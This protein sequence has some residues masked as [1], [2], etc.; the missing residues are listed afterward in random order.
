VVSSDLTVGDL[1]SS[2]TALHVLAMVMTDSSDDD[3]ILGLAASALPSLSHHCRVE[4]VWL[5]G[6]WRSVDFLGGRVRP[7]AGLEAEV[8]NLGPAGGA[9]R[10]RDVEWA[11]AFPLSS[12]GGASG[13]LVVGAPEQ[14]PEHERSLIGALAHQTGVALANARLLVRERTIRSRLADEQAVLRRVAMLVARAAPPEE[15]FAAVAAEAGRLLD[16]DF[17]VMSR[18][19]AH[20]TATVVGTWAA[21]SGPEPLP[22]RTRMEREHGGVHALVF[23]TDRPARIE[24]Y[25][26]RDGVGANIAKQWGVRAAVGVPIHIEGRL[27]GIIGVASLRDESLPVDTEYCLAGFTELVAAAIANAET[28]AAL[29]ASR[30]RIVAAADTARHR[31]QRDLHDGAQQR[32]VTLALR[33][34]AA[35]AAVPPDAGDLATELEQLAEGLAAAHD[36]LREIACGIHPVALAKG[37]LVPALTGLARRSTVPV[38][39][40]VRIDARLPEQIELAAYY[41]VAE[42]LT[43]AAKHADADSIDVEVI[44]DGDVV[45]VCVRDDGRGGADPSHGSGLVGLKDRVET[46][47]G[48]ISLHSPLGAG[49]RVK[50]E[51]PFAGRL[52]VSARPG[53]SRDR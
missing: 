42:A 40:D 16:A 12:R 52:T 22:P 8:A 48:R 36:E 17:A 23:A 11:W 4:A 21:S 46:L 47:G 9:L 50:I 20:G 29:T 10:L 2:L 7:C 49:T 27:W 41:V 1:L 33:L 14:P 32:L 3:A 19:D 5:D 53:A 28:Q 13:Y 15:V 18:Y 45:R 39:L 24:D 30:A 37:G 51:L 6:A 43:N 44:T 25:G 31:L 38:H 35:Q 34:R 26:E